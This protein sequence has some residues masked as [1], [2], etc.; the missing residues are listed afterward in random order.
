M[1]KLLQN[2]WSWIGIGGL[3]LALALLALVQGQRSAAAQEPQTGDIVTA[4][5]GDLSAS[6]TASGN[7]E[8]GQLAE[9]ALLRG[10][11][12]ADIYVAVGDSVAESEPLLQLET[13]VLQR[14]V[15]NAEQAV[16]IQET[17]LA[18][19]QEP[20]TAADLAAAEAN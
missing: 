12:V 9:L 2:K 3:L 11:T 7:I 8:A 5:V 20:A 15:A 14:D 1:K 19:L 16:V 13:A 4:F 18:T 17:N 10:G 6:A